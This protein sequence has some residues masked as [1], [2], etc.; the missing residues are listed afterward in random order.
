MFPVPALVT[1]AAVTGDS[2]SLAI[3]AQAKANFG[4][5]FGC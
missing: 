1:A 4:H 5:S 3:F 2:A